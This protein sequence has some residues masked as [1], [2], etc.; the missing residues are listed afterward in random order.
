M[1]DHIRG[2][3]HSRQRSAD[4]NKAPTVGLALLHL[5]LLQDSLSLVMMVFL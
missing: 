3:K 5:A 2:K 4:T 1:L